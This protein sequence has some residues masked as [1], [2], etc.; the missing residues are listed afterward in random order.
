MNPDQCL[1]FDVKSW[2]WKWIVCLVLCHY[3]EST[4]AAGKQ[5]LGGTKSWLP[6]QLQ[7]PAQRGQSSGHPSSQRQPR[8]YLHQCRNHQRLKQ[9]L[10]ST[11]LNSF[12]LLTFWLHLKGL[13]VKVMDFPLKLEAITGR[14]RLQVILLISSF[15]KKKKNSWRSDEAEENMKLIFFTLLQNMSLTVSF[16]RFMTL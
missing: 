9:P 15:G 14:K 8:A 11:F 7:L 3:S 1:I 6:R 12:T 2:K 4:E 5:S 13:L 16:Y 10:P